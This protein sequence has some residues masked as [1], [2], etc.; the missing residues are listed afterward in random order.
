MKILK[1]IKEQ[2]KTKKI[3][4]K[5]CS[6]N[7]KLF[8]KKYSSSKNNEI[9]VEFNGFQVN[10]TGLAA[11]SN[12]LA[13]KFNAKIN[14]YIGYS[15]VVSP[16]KYNTARTIKW[17]LC[18]FLNLK[19]FKIYRSFNT[20]KIFKPNINKETAIE[21]EK[22]FKKIWPKIKKKD[23]ILKIKLRGIYL[24]DLIYDT[25]IKANFL[26][27]IDIN[28]PKFK[29]YF[30]DFLELFIFW[31]TYFKNH[32]VKAIIASHPVYTYALPLRIAARF[33]ALAYVLDIEHFFQITEK[34]LYQLSD[35]K[36][37]KKTAKSLSKFQLKKG[38]I[39]AKNKLL[40]RISGEEGLKI[41]YPELQKSAFHNK[42]FKP[43]IKKNNKI[44]ILIC[45]HEYF[46]APHIFGKN[47]FPDFYEWM[48]CLGK[49]SDETPDYDWYIKTHPPQP[50]KYK[51]YQPLNTILVKE[52]VKKYKNI[53][54]LPDTYSH[55]Q[56]IKEKINFVLTTYGSVAFEYP[57]FNIPVI[58]ATKNH[59]H[60]LYDFITT[61]RS[62]KEYI[63]TIKNL[64]DLNCKIN[65]E[66]IYEYYYIRFI[67]NGSLNWMVDYSRA[68]KKFKYW[69]AMFS[70]KFYEFYMNEFKQ[71]K[72]KYTSKK[73]LE[74]I[75]SNQYRIKNYST[76]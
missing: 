12:V 61:P 24:G 36:D 9:L 16:L 4:N 19:T 52:F 65:K 18:N 15:F 33:K 45:T 35:C 67:K 17:F 58:M 37:Y 29:T 2:I 28:D 59:T 39:E 26:P 42:S 14:G 5:Y 41:D 21:A 31:Y 8:K 27:T 53:K 49:I 55:K 40:Q 72:F 60:R 71:K 22:I 74:Y 43:M 69:S 68:I 7:K 62:Q 6:F 64:K 66:E 44:K 10:H 75:N 76:K 3:I 63:D 70:N 50:G 13:K 32:N 51:I 23:D 57:L 56:I 38:K 11:M 34:N 47:L 1:I 20:D 48:E 30:H 25:Y 54:L 46:D 73:Y